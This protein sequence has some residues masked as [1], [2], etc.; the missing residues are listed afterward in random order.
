ML[1]RSEIGQT[2]EDRDSSGKKP[3]PLV[4]EITRED[5]VEQLL[6][7]YKQAPNPE[8]M[9][10]SFEITQTY[11][12][13]PCGSR[14]RLD[15]PYC[16]RC[17]VAKEWL[18]EHTDETYLAQQIVER[19]GKT[20]VRW[21]PDDS[22]R[23]PD[24]KTQAASQGRTQE[25]SSTTHKPQTHAS[26]TQTLQAHKPQAHPSQ[27]QTQT[28]TASQTKTQTSPTNTASAHKEKRNNTGIERVPTRLAG[29]EG[30][31]LIKKLKYMSQFGTPARRVILVL[32]GLILL[33]LLAILASKLLNL[34]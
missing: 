15:R 1:R 16:G 8:M 12:Q 7:E 9:Q 19:K 20:A 5:L 14:N 29:Y 21:L 32:A 22:A 28:T 31:I 2:H 33:I 4:P 3:V 25:A 13:C 11:W 26:Q 34:L 27:A 18:Q 6:I 10:Y 30:N 17:G 24:T 23:V